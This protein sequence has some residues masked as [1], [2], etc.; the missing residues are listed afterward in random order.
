MAFKAKLHIEGHSTS[1]DGIPISSFNFSFSQTI[2]QTGQPT[3]RVNGGIINLSIQ[4]LND[5][6]IYSWMFSQNA[7]KKGKIVLASDKE[8]GQSFQTVAFT[9]AVLINYDQIFSES[10]G[11]IVNLTISCREMDISGAQFFNLWQ[12]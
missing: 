12:A 9:D 2:G 3:S 10:G 1:Q 11:V 6:D 7:K 5:F 8:T 4:D